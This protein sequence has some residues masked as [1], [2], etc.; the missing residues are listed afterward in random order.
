MIRVLAVGFGPYPGAPASPG[1]EIVETLAAE[2]WSPEGAVLETA[3]APT[4][5]WAGPATTLEA[6]ARHAP[7]AIVLFA[8]ARGAARLAVAQAARNW[9]ARTPDS[10][11]LVWP[12][13]ELAPGAPAARTATLDSSALALAMHAAGVPAEII[14]DG[15]DFV[16]NRAFYALLSEPSAPPSALVLA[17]ASLESARKLG[18]PGPAALNRATILAGAQA[19]LGFAASAAARRRTA[20]A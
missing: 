9:A 10:A 8:C 18:L 20:A 15:G 6:A 13:R 7:A 12:G 14:A 3:V 17:P 2:R 16:W 1:L 5:W 4:Q 19:A 11:G